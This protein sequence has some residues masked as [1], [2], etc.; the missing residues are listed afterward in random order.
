MTALEKVIQ[1]KKEG[2]G[3]NEII[4]TLRNEGV[5]PMNISDAL[6]QSRIK[7][8]IVDPNPTEGMS[9]SIM[10]GQDSQTEIPTAPST[11]PGQAATQ[12][13]THYQS[14]Q[15]S[16]TQ[17]AY[18]PQQ[19]TEPQAPQSMQ[20]FAPAPTNEYAGQDTYAPQEQS[21]LPQDTYGD[22]Y[23][24]EGGYQDG[25]YGSTDAM[26][27]VSEQV[28]AEKTKKIDKDLK[29]LRE[30]KTIFEANVKNIDE[31]LKRMER[32]FD[33][34]QLDILGKVSEYGKGL[35]YMKKELNMVQD[36]FGKMTGKL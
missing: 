28:F 18:A 22:E 32:S 17:S 5:S 2:K 29:E 12:Q 23:Q 20:E 14:P 1:L 35:N 9:P 16:P 33:K 3:D 4:A 25:G 11:N 6:N 8:A 30:F 27:E 7:E 19:T 36:S 31:R 10:D 26:I 24:D 13:N 21:Y 15:Q 34:M